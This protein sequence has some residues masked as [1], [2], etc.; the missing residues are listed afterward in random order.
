M[1]IKRERE[2]LIMAAHEQTIRTN[3][4]KAKKRLKLK[5]SVD[6]VVKWKTE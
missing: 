3:V 2:S 4:I 5:V 6:C 1:G